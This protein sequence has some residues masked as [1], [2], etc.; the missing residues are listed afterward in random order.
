M[1]ASSFFP[2]QQSRLPKLQRRLRIFMALQFRRQ[3]FP[4]FVIDWVG[5]ILSPIE[6]SGENSET[7]HGMEASRRTEREDHDVN[8]WELLPSHV[9]G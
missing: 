6:T 5:P 9:D 7:I 4:P 8:F 1:Q 2:R 3:P